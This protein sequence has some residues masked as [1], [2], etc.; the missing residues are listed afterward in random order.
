M[1]ENW[2]KKKKNRIQQSACEL[3]KRS[4]KNFH[5]FRYCDFQ[6]KW[7][8]SRKCEKYKTEIFAQKHRAHR[9]VVWWLKYWQLEQVSNQFC[10][11]I[12]HR[13]EWCRG[14]GESFS[15]LIL[16]FN[17]LE[18]LSWF[19]KIE[20]NNKKKRKIIVD[21]LDRFHVQKSERREVKWSEISSWIIGIYFVLSNKVRHL[22]ILKSCFFPSSS[23]HT[24]P[25][26]LYQLL[27]GDGPIDILSV[28]TTTLCEKSDSLNVPSQ[29]NVT[30][31]SPRERRRNDLSSN[32]I[33]FCLHFCV[34]LILF[35]SLA[36]LLTLPKR[37]DFTSP[38]GV[39]V[40]YENTVVEEVP[41][42]STFRVDSVSGRVGKMK[43]AKLF[44]RISSLQLSLSTEHAA[45]AFDGK[46]FVRIS[47]TLSR[48]HS[49]RRGNERSLM[50]IL[51]F[52]LVHI[53]VL[54]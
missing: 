25:H 12:S 11:F 10:E 30:G 42:P 16:N 1:N 24:N 38:I 52:P 51:K 46:L 7:K 27:V 45:R 34:D 18:T 36:P 50:Q 35:Y 44:C 9:R 23:S 20:L 37:S 32:L 21:W 2:E 15:D 5:F 26:C 41:Q 53:I 49:V 8:V 43:N 48:R 40:C 29:W 31:N 3:I 39:W 14:S 6:W 47:T 28:S 17:Q 19:L 22:D 54:R 4:T 13:V 33:E